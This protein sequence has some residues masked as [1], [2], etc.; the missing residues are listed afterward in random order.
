[1]KTGIFLFAVLCAPA[2]AYPTTIYVPDDYPTI[3]EGIDAAMNGDTVVVKP[4]T[5]HELIDFLGKAITVK[6]EQGAATTVIDGEGLEGSIVSF[7]NGESFDSVLQGFTLT[8]GIGTAGYYYAYGGGIYCNDASPVIC[9]N[10]IINNGEDWGP[11]FGTYGGGIY[12]NGFPTILNNLIIGNEGSY[13]AGIYCGGTYSQIITNNTIVGNSGCGIYIDDS[14]PKVA[15]TI[16]WNNATYGAEIRIGYYTYPCT[17]FISYSDLEGGPDA[18]YVDPDCSVDWGPGMI[19]AD[20]LFEDLLNNDCHLS[21]YSPCID[22]G[23]N[24]VPGILDKDIDGD[25]RIFDG[26]CD[27]LAVVDMGCDELVGLQVPL[28]YSTIQGAIQD[29]AN[30]D[31]VL[32]AAGTYMERIDFLGKAVQVAG[33]AG[34]EAT[35]IDGGQVGSVAIFEN[36]EGPDS[37]LEGFTLTNG[38]GWSGGG[39]LCLSASP[40][41]RYNRIQGNTAA[42]EDGGGIFCSLS[43]A[44]IEKNIITQNVATRMGGGIG[45]DASSDLLIADNEIYGNQ[46]TSGCGI[47]CLDS[48]PRNLNNNVHENSAYVGGGLFAEILA[49]PTITNN[50]FYA[51]TALSSGGGIHCETEAL[52]ITNTIVWKNEAPADPQINGTNAVITYCDVEG[53]W[54]GMGNMDADPLFLDPASGDL[55]LDVQSPCVDEG[56]PAAPELPDFDF[57]GDPRSIYHSVDIGADEYNGHGVIHVPYLA[58]TIKAGIDLA[59]DG[60]TVLVEPG[61]YFEN[62]YVYAKAVKLKSSKGAGLTTIDGGGLDRVVR[63]SYYCNNESALQGFTITNGMGGFHT[64]GGI[65]C[66]ESSPVIE[67]NIITGNHGSGII[68]Q[69]GSH[70]KIRNNIITNNSAETGAGIHIREYSHPTVINCILSHNTATNNGGGI[71]VE[72]KCHPTLT[73]CVFM[74]NAALNSSSRGGGVYIKKESDSTLTSCAFI[75]NSATYGGGGIAASG[76]TSTVTNCTFLGNTADRGGAMEI[77]YSCDATITNTISWNNE[78][79]EGP[80]INLNFSDLTISYSDIEGGQE[81]IYQNWLS[82]LYWGAGMIEADPLFVDEAIGDCHLTFLSPC[83]GSGDNTVVTELFDFE[84]DPRICQGTVDIGADECYRHLYC[85]GDFSPTG[86]IE[87]KLVGLPGTSPVSLFLGSGVLEPPLPTA[88]GNFHLQ[89]PWYLIPLVPIPAEGVLILPATIPATPPAPY[90]LPMQALIG[91]NPDSLTNLWVLEV[92]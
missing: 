20:P 37:I 52:I 69:Y 39:V 71:Y 28:G 5:Y 76:G 43:L 85:T 77:A 67:D 6:S 7:K 68:C 40:T 46:A 36:G 73:G 72:D 74:G 80:E 26:N 23:S 32:V 12:C 48:S 31:I 38:M 13:G 58:P 18:I 56:D 83:R 44:H 41:L 25:E 61:T 62:L 2:L 55:H 70:A 91:L 90:D 82:N 42:A 57:E 66:S 21:C 35:I 63:F 87:G 92:R 19:D 50:T 79:L 34:C 88:W 15:N 22:A 27:G 54:P 3:Q 51:N 81:A 4:G 65:L 17:L 16:L 33:I 75:G 47:S 9:D 78:A 60:D 14:S 53:G 24:E 89:A 8:N 64:F 45:C 59:E 1:M 29:A 86:A 49:V 30:G 10:I 84:D 11:G